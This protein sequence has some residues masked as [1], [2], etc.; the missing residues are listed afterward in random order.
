VGI[1]AGASPK[2]EEFPQ[3]NDNRHDCFV[4]HRYNLAY[5]HN[6]RAKLLSI[7]ELAAK[8]LGYAASE[9]VN[10]PM[11]KFIPTEAYYEFDN[12]LTRIRTSGCESGLMS[13]V[14]RT[15]ERRMWEYHNTLRTWGLTEPIV[16]CVARDVTDQHLAVAELRLSEKKFSA[17]FMNSPLVT[18]ITTL[19]GDEFVDVNKMFER[20]TGFTRREV[21]GRKSSELG[22]WIE[23]GQRLQMMGEI[24]VVGQIRTREARFRNRSG[25]VQTQLYSAEL[26]KVDGRECVLALCQEL[27]Q[28]DA[29]ERLTLSQ[30]NYRSLFLNSPCGIYRVTLDGILFFVDDALVEMLGYESADELLSKSLAKALYADPND[31]NVTLDSVQ[32]LN[33]LTSVEM[34]WKRKSGAQILVRAQARGW[35]SDELGRIIGLET[36]VEDIT[37]QRLLDIQLRQVQKM[38]SLALLA[39]GI[40]HDF[41]NVLTG[42]LGYGQLALKALDQIRAQVQ[43]NLGPLTAFQLRTLNETMAQ[44]QHIVDAAFHGQALTGQLLAFSRDES[45]PVYPLNLD[46]EIRKTEEMIGRL[47][48]EHIR[49]QLQ[50]DCEFQQVLGERGAFGQVIL[51]LCA[52]ARDA[53]PRGGRLTVRTFPVNVK[54]GGDEHVDVPCGR[55]VVLQVADNGCGMHKTVQH[56]MCEPFFTTKPMGRG[57][58]LGLYIVFAVLRRCGGHMRVESEIGRG[59]TFS[60]Y[61]PVLDEGRENSDHSLDSTAAI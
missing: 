3:D 36:A 27:T 23:P 5:T 35:I 25:A 40:A 12:Y 49:V 14:T 31:E 50:L 42:V 53:M 61:L 37:Q 44:L 29:D 57:S 16:G 22:I 41:N 43:H 19:E 10:V 21:I 7:G 24:K 47:F 9:I 46:A 13:V 48:G 15:G 18:A 6:V 38:E 28:R 8:T 32:E 39:G 2:L 26:I 45:L 52:N 55:Y 60:L 59:S 34:Y 1:A 17:A 4:E 54:L 33:P 58:G 30:R 56:R 20:Q 11:K 51:N